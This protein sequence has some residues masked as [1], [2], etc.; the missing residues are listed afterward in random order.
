MT[1]IEAALTDQR[2]L[3]RGAIDI[4]KSYNDYVAATYL[5]QVSI[6]SLSSLF[7]E[8]GTNVNSKTLFCV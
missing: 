8:D 1:A 4:L 6:G 3:Y 5:S 7:L 2:G